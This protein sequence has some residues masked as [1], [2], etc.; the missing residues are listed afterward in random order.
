MKRLLSRNVIIDGKNI[1]MAIVESEDNET[2]KVRSFI[3][4]EAATGYVDVPIHLTAYGSNYRLVSQGKDT[5][6]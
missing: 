6:R 1:G 4:E 5:P 2:F 3:K